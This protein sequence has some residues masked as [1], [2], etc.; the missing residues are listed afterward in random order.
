MITSKYLNILVV[1]LMSFAVLAAS[2]LTLYPHHPDSAAPAEPEYASKLFN[3]EQ[4]M[5]INIEMEP[6]DFDWIIENATRE[7]YRQA[8]ITINGNTYHNVGIRPKGNSSLR[9]VA[10]DKNS[11][12]FSFKVK[13]DAYVEGQACMGLN[14]LAL[15]NIIMDKTYMKEYLAYEIFDYMGVVTPKYAYANISINSKPW[16]LYLAVEAMEESFVKRNYGSL[17][18][19][20]YRPEGAGSDLKWAGEDAANYTG[21]RKMAAYNVTDSDFKKIITMIEQLNNGSELEKYLDIDSILR[22]F[23]VNSFLVNFDSYVGSLKHNYYL[24][25]ENGVCTILPWDFNLAFAGHE[26]S[27]A[28]KAVNFPIDTP[29]TVNLSERP[30]I[31]KLLE[32]PEYRELYHKYL[33]QLTEDY[34]NSGRFEDSVE[35][36]D[37]MINSSVKNDATAFYSHAEY[38]K[39][40]P[41][42]VEFARLRAQS[43]QAQLSG[44]QAATATGQNENSTPNIDASGIDLSALGGMGG[45]RGGGARPADGGGAAIPGMVK[46][47]GETSKEPGAPPEGPGVFPRGNRPDPETMMKAFEIMREAEGGQLSTAQIA[48][49][50]ELGLDDNMIDRMRNR[51]AAMEG[52]NEWAPP[53]DRANG[54]DGPFGGRALSSRITSTEIAYVAVATL[55]ILLG[56]LFVWKYKRRKYSS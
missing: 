24:Y 29:L 51:P 35:K 25:E 2:F 27:S 22:Y 16:G 14:K 4:I 6:E 3:K 43:I 18:G 23:A 40:L 39:S 38:E 48:R 26:I 8:D 28:Q 37:K 46:P 50:Q 55:S 33:Q 54:P 36:L 45:D 30:L 19:H 11:D 44:E 12:R 20:L 49:L 7:E 42:L 32:I 5:E 56:L 9:M 10:Q 47:E 21:I 53:G 13:F 31:G 41:V 17:E 34:I 15:N 52:R 1:I